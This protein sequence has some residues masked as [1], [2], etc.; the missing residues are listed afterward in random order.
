MAGEA[1]AGRV[2]VWSAGLL[3]RG[4]IQQ[5]VRQDK[6]LSLIYD[7]SAAVV[8]LAPAYTCVRP[9]PWSQS[10]CTTYTNP[11]ALQEHSLILQPILVSQYRQPSGS[12]PAAPKALLGVPAYE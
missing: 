9:T 1:E 10:F 3:T 6:Q 7:L 4:K 8:V 2:T 12:S 11:A 5:D